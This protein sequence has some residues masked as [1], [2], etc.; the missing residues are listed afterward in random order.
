[1]IAGT[2]EAR[3]HPRTLLALLVACLAASLAGWRS[4]VVALLCVVAAAPPAPRALGLRALSLIGSLATLLLVL[5][6][7]PQAAADIAVRGVAASLALV[8]LTSGM[9]WPAAI[10]EL[11]QL[12]LPRTAVAFLALLARHV[13]VLVGDARSVVDVLKV[14]G[15]F[16]RKANVLRAVTALLARLLALAW[17]RADRVADAMTSRGFEGRLPPNAGWQPRLREA[18]QYALTLVVV[19]AFGW[20]V[21]R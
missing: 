3:P 15:A 17:L 5:P 14:R 4:A 12:G 13:E 1:V 19:V 10:A 16:D 21:A 18:R 11:Q 9:T 7:A 8:F 6:F 20:Q 2:V